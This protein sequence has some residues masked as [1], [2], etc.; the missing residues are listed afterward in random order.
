MAQGKANRDVMDGGKV[1]PKPHGV[2]IS[3]VTNIGQQYV[4]TKQPPGMYK[5]DGFKAP[6]HSM[7]THKAGSQR[8]S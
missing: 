5:S 3:H 2:S 8:K 4:Y 1:E 7:A 6:M